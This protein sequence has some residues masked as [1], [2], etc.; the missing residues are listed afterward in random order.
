VLAARY[1]EALRAPRKQ[2]LWFEQSSHMPNTEERDAFN[3]VMVETVLPA[4][5]DLGR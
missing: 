3:R 5:P 2:L 4:L 1:F